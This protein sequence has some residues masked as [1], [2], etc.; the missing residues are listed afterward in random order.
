MATHKSSTPVGASAPVVSTPTATG[1]AAASSN[2]TAA[3][4]AA[5]STG[6]AVGAGGVLSGL[7][8]NN[9]GLVQVSTKSLATTKFS[10]KV[11]ARLTGVQKYLPAGTSLVFLGQT[12]SMASIEA[13]LS[14][15]AQLFTAFTTAVQDSKAQV[16]AARTALNA[17]LPTAHQFLTALDGALVAFFG[18]GNP[19]LKNF[20]LSP[21]TAKAPSVATKA[22]AQAD[23]KLTREARDTTGKKAKLAVTGGEA[24][25]TVTGPN[26]QVLSGTA[27]V[28]AASA[29]AGTGGSSGSNSSG[30]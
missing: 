18:K 22:K 6:S 30:S 15:V 13:V 17:E 3:G 9:P 24:T 7:G 10:D 29:A 28:G 26:G 4:A 8:L 23:A 14:A 11:T 1:V 20:G 25:V 27:P 12:F 16:G 5:G 2:S 21:G 19:V